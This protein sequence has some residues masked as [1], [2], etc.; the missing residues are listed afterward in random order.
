MA[1]RGTTVHYAPGYGPLCGSDCQD[2]ALTDNPDDVTGCV[3][4]LDLAAEDLADHNEYGGRCLHCRREITA[5]GGVAWR[6]AVRQPCPHCDRPG[7]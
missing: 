6:R 4:C 5:R 3:D 2:A 7:W 1:N